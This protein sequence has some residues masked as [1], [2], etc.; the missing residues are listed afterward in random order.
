MAGKLHSVLGIS[1]LHACDDL[2]VGSLDVKLP[3]C[4]GIVHVLSGLEPNSSLVVGKVLFSVLLLLPL[5][6]PQC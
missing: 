1:Y 4:G 5:G 6:H 3:A 2:L